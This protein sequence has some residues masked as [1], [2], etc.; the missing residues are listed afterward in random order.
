[1]KNGTRKNRNSQKY[2]APITYHRLRPEE[3]ALA[4]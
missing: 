3:F 1:M 4:I 2:G